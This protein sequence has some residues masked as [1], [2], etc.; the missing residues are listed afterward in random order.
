[1]GVRSGYDVDV[2]DDSVEVYEDGRDDKIK[3]KNEEVIS[4]SDKKEDNNQNKEKDFILPT[5]RMTMKIWR[6][7]SRSTEKKE[8][9]KEMKNEG[10]PKPVQERD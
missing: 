1:M 5:K 8:K 3:I 4:N 7:C 10:H 9:K 6:C 2:E